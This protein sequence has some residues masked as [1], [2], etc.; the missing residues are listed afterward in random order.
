MLGL[1]CVGVCV[2]VLGLGCMCVCVCDFA[3]A[4]IAK[5]S[6]LRLLNRRNRPF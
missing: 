1:G 4:A 5:R 3:K 6:G 2:C